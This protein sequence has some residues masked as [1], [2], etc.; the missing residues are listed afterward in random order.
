MKVITLAF[1]T[2]VGTAAVALSV[3]NPCVAVSC[4]DTKDNLTDC[5][6]CCG[7]VNSGVCQRRCALTHD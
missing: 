2:V 5:L 4:A 6:A 7:N 3:I 1:L